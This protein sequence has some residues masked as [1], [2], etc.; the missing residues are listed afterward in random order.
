MKAKD[1]IKS[2]KDI[3]LK[4]DARRKVIEACDESLN[5]KKAV[6]PLWLRL[7]SRQ[8]AF[9]MMAVVLIVSLLGYSIMMDKFLG[10]TVPGDK[11]IISTS[12]GSQQ[13][14]SDII[15]DD[16]I[17]GSGNFTS[18]SSVSVISQ[19]STVGQTKIN[20]PSWYKPGKLS[21]IAVTHPNKVLLWSPEIPMARFSARINLLSFPK[22][23]MSINKF[24]SYQ[25]NTVTLPDG[26]MADPNRTRWADYL[27]LSAAKSYPNEDNL[28]YRLSDS[29]IIRFS[30]EAKTVLSKISAIPSGGYIQL[31]FSDPATGH[32]L[33]EVRSSSHMT[34]GLYY[35][36]INNKKTVSLPVTIV[37][38]I[39]TVSPDGER[40]AMVLTDT[41]G[42]TE[43]VILDMS[44]GNP[45]LVTVTDGKGANLKPSERLFFTESGKHLIFGTADEKGNFFDEKNIPFL[46]AYNIQSKKTIRVHGNFVRTIRDEE[47]FVLERV[48]KGVV[49]RSDNAADVSDSLKLEPWESV[50]VQIDSVQIKGGAMRSNASKVSLFGISTPSI[51]IKEAGAVFSSGPYLYTYKSGSSSVICQHTGTGDSFTVPISSAFVKDVSG[52]KAKGLEATFYFMLSRDQTMLLLQYTTAKYF[53]TINNG[54]YYYNDGFWRDFLEADDLLD[55]KDFVDNGKDLKLGLE[56]GYDP[57]NFKNINRFYVVEGEGYTS[58]IAISEGDCKIA[59]EDYRDRTF[60][61]YRPRRTEPWYAAPELFDISGD[62][63]SIPKSSFRKKLSPTAS[64]EKSR[65]LYAGLG[66]LEPYYDYA[67]FYTSGNIDSEK[68]RLWLLRPELAD[69][70]VPQFSFIFEIDQESQSGDIGYDI[71]D[72][73]LLKK[74]LTDIIAI[75]GAK[76]IS[77]INK[78]L[79]NLPSLGYIKNK[80]LTR[81]EYNVH[82]N[83]NNRLFKG[84]AN[85]YKMDIGIDSA[86]RYFLRTDACYWFLTKAQ[87]DNLISTLKQLSIESKAAFGR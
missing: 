79:V 39:Y 10:S 54:P 73:K 27:T 62:N 61:L 55:F 57:E 85:C 43:L 58:L 22:I 48:G 38:S 20:V 7:N 14:N 25:S 34:K 16:T 42:Q 4:D 28:Y 46:A 13:I 12:S 83:I 11:S 1:L 6:R 5:N 8:V 75:P 32:S 63:P 35:F 66:R 74:L 49:I 19:T 44:S 24:A 45:T 3:K 26:V 71:Y 9:P 76:P 82:I 60:T 21:L 18:G 37:N 78:G 65:E 86:G 50:R 87:H 59:V 51:S 17:S 31:L 41:E 53:D 70:S 23:F 15:S 29:K 36:N 67:D 72:K 77:D 2:I 47:Y 64:A 69:E 40:L 56:Q 30:Y 52:L 81:L 80:G 33:V 68:I 84:T